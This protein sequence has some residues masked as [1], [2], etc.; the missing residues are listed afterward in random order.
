MTGHG[1]GMCVGPQPW[2]A[3]EKSPAIWT[4]KGAGPK[5]SDASGPSSSASR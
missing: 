3:G 1:S 4:S 5:R 2:T